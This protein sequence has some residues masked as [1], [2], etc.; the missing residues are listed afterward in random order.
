ML[1]QA[2]PLFLT[3]IVVFTIFP[4]APAVGLDVST[5]V[6]V[7]AIASDRDHFPGRRQG[8]GN[9]AFPVLTALT[10]GIQLSTSFLNVHGGV[11]GLHGVS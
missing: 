7:E 2:S 10:N 1:T 8:G 3:L 5:S 4:A 6:G 11:S 9:Y